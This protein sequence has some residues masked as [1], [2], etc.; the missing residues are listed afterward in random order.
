MERVGWEGGWWTPGRYGRGV[1]RSATFRA[2]VVG[3][4]GRADGR[5]LAFE[6]A[7]VP[8]AWQL[9]QGGLHDDE[10]PLAAAWREVEEE[11]GLGAADLELVAEDP[12][13][14]VYEVPADKRTPKFGLGQ[15]QR[16]FHFRITDDQIEP[17]PDQRE[18]IAWRWVDPD[19]LIA[20]VV[21]WRRD[22]YRRGLAR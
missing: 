7:D 21:E 8:G 2:G 16:W 11:T 4:V 10:S 20:H 9:P 18:F 5:V 19:W 6:R 15:A 13:W 3:V 17:R 14:I 22:S 1:S 12:E